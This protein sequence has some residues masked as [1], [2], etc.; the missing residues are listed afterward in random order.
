VSFLTL[1]FKNLQRRR[2]R[3]L[4]TITGIA[5]GIAAVVALSSIAWGFQKSWVQ[6]YTAR[7]TDMIVTKV[8]S[9]DPLP[10]PFGES[11][12]DE[13]RNLPHVQEVTGVLSDLVSIEDA[14]TVL[15]FGWER[16]TFIWAHLKLVNGRWPADDREST[17]VI[18]TVAAEMM[19]KSVGDS[20]H[21]EN[22]DFRICGI[23][24]STAFVEN[25]TVI[26][27]LPQM[28]RVMDNAGKVNILNFRLVPGTTE[29]EAEALRQTIKNR[30]PGYNAFT[31]GEVAQSNMGIQAAKAMSWATSFIALAVGAVGVANTMLMSVFERIHE[32]GILLAIGWKRSRIVR[33]IIYESMALSFIG[34]ICGTAL[35]Y[36]AVNLLEATPWIHGKIEGEFNL[37][38]CGL[39]LAIALGLGALGGLYPA[40]RGSRLHPS[41]ALRHE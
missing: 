4:L 31:G 24:S 14:P 37:P 40:Y 32:I 13:L 26:M 29:R 34:G 39:A 36:G 33:L 5:V 2:T 3:S 25:G 11:I 8:T 38:L 41:E 17:V 6:A 27:A 18:G 9:R 19:K 23:F 7:G 20:L 30:F 1:V 15:V 28:Q 35:G 21:I 16:D 10:T 12:K 22:D